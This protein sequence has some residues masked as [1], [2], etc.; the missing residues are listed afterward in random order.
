MRPVGFAGITLG[1]ILSSWEGNA[2]DLPM[3]E[4]LFVACLSGE[5]QSCRDRSMV[6]T[7]DI[8]LMGCMM[9]AQAQLAKWA[10]SHPGQSIS[11]WKCR[12]AGVDGRAA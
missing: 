7:S 4:L 2:R 10:Q 9:G 11:G 3:I 6:F 8:G 1:G 5:P 12:M